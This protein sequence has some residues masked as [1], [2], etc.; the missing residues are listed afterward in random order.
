MKKTRAD[1]QD[2]NLMPDIRNRLLPA[3]IRDLAGSFF[4]YCIIA[5]KSQAG[6]VDM[7]INFIQLFSCI[8]PYAGNYTKA[9]EG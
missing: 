8:Y 1:G 2:L 7:W 4:K 9:T 3:P 6:G 5:G